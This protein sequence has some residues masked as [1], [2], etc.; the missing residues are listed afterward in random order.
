[1]NKETAST[2]G[3]IMASLLS[4][5]CCIGPVVF[6]VFGT[7]IGIFGKLSFLEPVSPYLLGVGFVMLSYSFWR[8]YLKRAD[9]NCREDMRARKIGRSIFWAG[10]VVFVFAVFFQKFI[11]WIYG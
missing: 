11:L 3:T 8:L 7:S 1:M 4:T 6:V 2:L 10:F 5:A 9:C